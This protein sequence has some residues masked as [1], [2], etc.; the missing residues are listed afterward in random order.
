MVRLT[1]DVRLGARGSRACTPFAARRADAVA[2]VA[3]G[4]PV[5]TAG[6]AGTIWAADRRA[7]GLF[8]TSVPGSP[9]DS[10]AKPPAVGIRRRYRHVAAGKGRQPG[11]ARRFAPRTGSPGSALPSDG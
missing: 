1:K 10:A 2:G 11:H 7:F 9:G 4:G 8:A 6:V 5:R 3:A